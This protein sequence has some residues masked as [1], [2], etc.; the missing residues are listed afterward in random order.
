MWESEFGE[1]NLDE[2]NRIDPGKNYGWPDCE[3]PCSNPKF[4]NPIRTWD[5]ASASPSGLEI[6]ND[7]LY[8]AAVRGSRLWVMKITGNQSTDTPRA[9][10]NNRWGRLRTVVKS[11]DGG[12]WLTSTNNDKSGGTPNV[13]D[14]VIVRLKFAGGTTNPF[15]LSSSAFATNGNIPTKY[16]CQ[17]DHA[18]GNDI[19]PPLAWGPGANQPKS[20]A[21]VLVDTANTKQHWA[22]WDIPAA[23]TSLSEGLGLG[24]NV[25]GV[26]GAHQKAM[27]SGNQSLQYFGPCPGGSSH[28]YNFT[29]YA[30]SVATLPG[31]SQ[32]ST[33]AQVETAAKANDLANTTLVGNSAA[34]T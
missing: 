10:F 34:H 9:F 12:L 28:T 27:G 3:G 33:V 25:P 11:P 1:G 22:I 19:S 26:A 30:L 6:V 4:T 18:A 21:I 23:T 7:W 31:L 32:S 15:T 8:M 24:F 2:L 17:Q 16:T 29:L 14:N 5:V 20:Y 13:L